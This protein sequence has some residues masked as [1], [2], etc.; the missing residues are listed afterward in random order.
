MAKKIL[1][2]AKLLKQIEEE[3]DTLIQL[4]DHERDLIDDSSTSHARELLGEVSKYFE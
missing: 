3:L 2:S 1:I 4:I